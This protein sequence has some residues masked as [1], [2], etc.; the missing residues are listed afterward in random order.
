MNFL[1]WFE[2]FIVI[3]IVRKYKYTASRLLEIAW[4]GTVIG[5]ILFSE[6]VLRVFFVF[7]ITGIAMAL[8]ELRNE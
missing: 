6:I 1:Y 5:A 8:I 7:W 4:W 2:L 3:Y